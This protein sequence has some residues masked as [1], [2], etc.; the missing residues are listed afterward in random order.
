VGTQ[1]QLH[2]LFETIAYVVGF[3]LY[4]WQRRR[5]GDVIGDGPR[6]SIVA[7][8]IAGAAFGSKLLYWLEEPGLTLQHANDLV[9][10][11]AG[12]TVVGGLV[13]GLIAVE[14][15]KKFIGVREATGDLF[16]VPLALGIAIGRI[17]CFLAGLQDRTYGLPTSLPWGVDFG[18][19]IARHPTQLYE[20]AFLAWLAWYLSRASVR[21]SA[22]AHINGD[23]FKLFMVSYLGLRLA[24]DFIKPGLAFFGLTSIQW[25]CLLTLVH[26]RRD[27][28]RWMTSGRAPAAVATS[29]TPGHADE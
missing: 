21:P 29:L 16:A 3:R 10:L 27:I 1:L 20:A 19:G 28:V 8:A 25:V 6:W 14:I 4:L 15:T 9:F 5:R 2:W 24:I 12:K 22:A 13:G 23:L 18:D 26:Y 7:A 11:M 17:G